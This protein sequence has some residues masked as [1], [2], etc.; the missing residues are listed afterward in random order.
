MAVEFPHFITMLVE[1]L[2]GM[3]GT[4]TQMVAVWAVEL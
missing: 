2:G 3:L 1:P 4:S